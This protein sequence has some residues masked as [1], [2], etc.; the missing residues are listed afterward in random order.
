MRFAD[1]QVGHILNVTFGSTFN[2]AMTVTTV[3][4]AE[5]GTVRIRAKSRN[6]NVR[7]QMEGFWSDEV[8][9]E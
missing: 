4:Q 9:Q 3:E 1:V 6:N 2:P 5:D 7:V 8:G